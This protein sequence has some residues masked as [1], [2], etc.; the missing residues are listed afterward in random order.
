M[1]STAQAF[2]PGK[3]GESSG[4]IRGKFRESSGN[5]QGKLRERE[6]HLL[7]QLVVGIDVALD[8]PCKTEIAH[9]HLGMM[10]MM[11]IMI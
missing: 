11:I 3:F 6:L 7:V 2:G 1:P 5:I 10:T 8:M 9:Q 4:K